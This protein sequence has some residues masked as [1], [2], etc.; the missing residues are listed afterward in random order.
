VALDKTNAV[1][2][3]L[4]VAGTVISMSLPADTTPGGREAQLAAYRA[5]GPAR[6]LAAAF[7][8]SEAVRQIAL[9]GCRSRH[10][11]WPE[12]RVR[13]SV[14]EILLGAD[15]AHTIPARATQR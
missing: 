6:R 8:M 14:A 7:E 13:R 11:D 15:V 9:A 12:D 1:G 3:L 2:H 4:V 10:P 5:M